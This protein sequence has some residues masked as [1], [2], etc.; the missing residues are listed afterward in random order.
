MDRSTINLTVAGTVDAINM[1]ESG[2]KEVSE[3]EMLE[4]LMFGHDAVKELCAIQ[5]DII[6]EIG[7]EKIEVVLANIPDEL[8]EEVNNDIKEDMIAA[9]QIK[10]KLEKYARIDEVKEEA[11]TKY[12]ER[13]EGEEDLEANLKLV[14]KIADEIEGNEVRR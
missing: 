6:S 8:R 5:N 4:A 9:I 3:E 11:L 13:H 12:S 1:V 10:D 14:K 2:S 7:L